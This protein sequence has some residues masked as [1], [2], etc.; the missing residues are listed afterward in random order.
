MELIKDISKKFDKNKLTI[1]EKIKI[2]KALKKQIWIIAYNSAHDLY[3]DKHRSQL[4]IAL[5]PTLK[6]LKKDIQEQNEWG[7]DD[8]FSAHIELKN[9]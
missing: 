8:P 9:K 1:Q 5:V 4:L 7:V 2:Y 3:M 6:W